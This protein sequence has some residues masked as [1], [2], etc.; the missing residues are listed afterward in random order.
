M[1]AVSA[2][3][4]GQRKRVVDTN[5]LPTIELRGSPRTRGRIHGETLR[6]KIR[7]VDAHHD[8]FLAGYFGVDPND[9]VADF[10]DRAH[11][12]PAIKAHAPD[13]IQEVEGLAEGANLSF[14][15]ALHMQLI[16]EEWAYGFYHH[17]SVEQNKCTSV[18]I[19]NGNDA[20]T[21]AGQNMDVPGYIDSNQI[22]FHIESD[23]DTPEAYVFSYAGL[24]GL[25]GLNSASIGICCNTLN[26]LEP[27]MTGLPV[28]FLVRSVLRQRSFDDARAF[29]T[30][31]PHASGQN[32]VLSAPGRIGAFECSANKVVEFRPDAEHRHVFHTNHALV[33]DD[34]S[35]YRDRMETLSPVNRNKFA[36]SHARLASI[37]ARLMA[38]PDSWTVDTLKAALRSRDNAAHPIC[39]SRDDM[40]D[41]FIGFTAG[42]MI[43]EHT[44]PPM[45]HLASGPPDETRYRKF[46]LAMGNGSGDDG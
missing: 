6:Q 34:Q 45:L 7:D 24:I 1:Q 39:R 27:S 42:S 44:E 23:G 43:Y 12:V 35:R 46:G 30:S 33:N 38:Q 9:Y 11:F 4:N 19:A 28:A 20:P 40:Q 22:L 2:L 15:K 13:L 3:A 18:G 31:V 41:S 32:Y 36:N 29:I 16:D 25:N 17:R 26:Q 37:E 21:V 10:L 5:D 14:A 8:R